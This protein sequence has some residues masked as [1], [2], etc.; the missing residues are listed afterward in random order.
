V[1]LL[2]LTDAPPPPQ[3]VGE[4]SSCCRLPSKHNVMPPITKR[5]GAC[6]DTRR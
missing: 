3:H 1:L 5:R 6:T 4:H 2:L